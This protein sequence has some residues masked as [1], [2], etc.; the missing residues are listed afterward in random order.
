[1]AK[2]VVSPSGN[3]SYTNE[4]AVENVIRYIT[5]SRI[6]EDRR[7][8]LI[9]YGGAGIGG[10][11]SPEEIIHQFLYVQEV[12]NIRNRRGRRICH[13]ILCLSDEEFA[14]LNCDYNLV[15]KIAQEI[16]YQYYLRGHQVLY[17]IHCSSNMRVHIHFAVN[18]INFITGLKWHSSKM[19]WIQ[20]E[21]MINR[22][23]SAY[24]YV[25]IRKVSL[26]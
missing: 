11:L 23:V 1:M 9:S 8:E 3:G 4:K 10:Y 6:Y 24:Y 20:R 25:F 7:N 18:T 2:L 12:Y 21:E 19:E 5:R 15:E 14:L 26:Q 13:E 16:R 22:I 17:G